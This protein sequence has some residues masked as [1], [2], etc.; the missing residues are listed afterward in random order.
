[1][2][3]D[4][5]NREQPSVERTFPEGRIETKMAIERR[6]LLAKTLKHIG[7]KKQF[8]IPCEF[9]RRVCVPNGTRQR[10]SKVLSIT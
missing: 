1:L 3:I 4:L 5:G 2:T 10:T 9:H 7:R 6:L 8:E